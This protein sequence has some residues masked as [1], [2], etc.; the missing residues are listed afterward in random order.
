[1]PIDNRFSDWHDI[2]KYFLGYDGDETR[3][4]YDDVAE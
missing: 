2:I 3:P 1:M 4:G